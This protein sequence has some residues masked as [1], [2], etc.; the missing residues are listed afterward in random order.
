MPDALKPIYPLLRHQP[1][2]KKLLPGQPDYLI[3]RPLRDEAVEVIHPKAPDQKVFA[4]N[5]KMLWHIFT[6]PE[7]YFT[8]LSTG[9]VI[10]RYTEAPR[11]DLDLRPRYV[12]NDEG[13]IVR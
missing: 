12:M 9:E 8:T 11:E 3:V 7:Y 5:P 2:D 13:Q 1:G 6:H 4:T 10:Q